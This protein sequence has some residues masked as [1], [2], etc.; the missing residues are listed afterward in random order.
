M[1]EGIIIGILGSLIP[2]GAMIGFYLY[3]FDISGG[4]LLG[5]FTLVSPTPF[6][7]YLCGGLL[8]LGILVG[9][10]GSYLSVSRLLRSKR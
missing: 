9:F 6:L 5:V 2:I 10:I 4:N 1:V 8:V 7:Y 3:A